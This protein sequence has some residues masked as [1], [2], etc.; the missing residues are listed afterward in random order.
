M[1]NQLITHKVKIKTN[2]SVDITG[3]NLVRKDNEAAT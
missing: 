1:S 2:R 3:L